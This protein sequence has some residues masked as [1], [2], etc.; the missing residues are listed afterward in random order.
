MDSYLALTLLVATLLWFVA[1]M[2]RAFFRVWMEHRI[3]MAR[4]Q[5]AANPCDPNTPE[6]L[7]NETVPVSQRQDYRVTGAFLAL[8]GALSITAGYFLGHGQTAVGI[9]VG[10]FVCLALGVLIAMAGMVLQSLAKPPQQ[11]SEKA[12]TL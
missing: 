6:Q 11:S 1:G 7:R 9:Y 12:S 2:V 5:N 4:F 3:R 10:G 8:G